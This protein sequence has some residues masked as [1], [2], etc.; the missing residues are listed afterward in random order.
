MTSNAQ[1]SN[2]AASCDFLITNATLL[3]MNANLD[4]F[5]S[6]SIAINGDTV[7]AVGEDAKA[8]APREVIDCG[9]RVVLPGFVNAHTHVPM[10][11][12]RGLA[13]D[14]RLDVWLMGY[15]MP[16]EREFVNP[17]F[18]RLGTSLACAEMIRSG[19]TCF[20]DMYYFEEAVAEATAAAG[21][22]ALCGQTVLKFRSPDASSYEDSLARAREFIQ[23]WK[24]H[25]L[26]VPAPAPHAPYT[27]TGEILRACADLA[28]EFDVPI[29]THLSETLT[30]VE[31]WR[32]THGMPV[33]PW[34]KKQGLFDAHV[35][36]AHCV[37]V[38]EGEMRTLR[39]AGAG[40]AHNPSSNLK[41]GSGVAPV[42]K[43]LDLGLT[44][45]IGT[46]G[47]ASNNDLDMFEEIRLAALLAKGTTGNPTAL[48]AR[49]AI[50]MATRLGAAALGLGHLTGSLEPGKRA[51]IIVVDVD[52][53]HNT[54]KFSRDPDAVYARLVYS[55]K[56]TDV[57]DV[58]CNGR[59]L[60]RNRQLLT[61]DEVTLAQGAR[62]YAK[63][64]DAFLIAREESVLQKLIAIGGAREE[65]SF[66][67]QVKAPLASDEPV[68][69]AIDGGEL[70]I[71]KS[72]RYHQYDTYFSFADPLHGRLRYREDEFLDEKGAVTRVR[73]R[74][75]LIGPAREA[76]LGSVLLFRSRFLAPANQSRRF[77]REYFRPTSERDVEKLRRRWLVAYKGVEFYV[78]LD[79]LTQPALPGYFLEI[80]S[81]TWSR[82]DANDKA[83]VIT[84]L[85]QVLGATPAE[86]FGDGYVDFE[87]PGHA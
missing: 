66:E 37:H 8:W 20:A 1:P 36:A 41:L 11:L 17:D 42:T 79:Q 81:R 10:T 82:R 72:V 31:E 15:V 9:G 16:V 44:V 56:S 49:Q 14:L 32:S 60:M 4:V 83:A 87:A 47:P 21:L 59:W 27:C 54:P 5:A 30:E 6:G 3:T 24:G 75:T 7:V 68:L 29:H 61:L 48:P 76:E 26:I 62:E 80:K 67:V 38:D 74:L 33:I 70:T 63:R 58:M 39:N 69:R 55:G 40:V 84:E 85:M 18:V 64:I 77:Y 12:L 43:M 65:E 46:D 71:I 53:L 50:L 22:R 73:V 78:H 57:T 25:P 34:V 52:P 45:G 51:D 19:I 2:A 28:V 23:A 13:D 86:A 35:L